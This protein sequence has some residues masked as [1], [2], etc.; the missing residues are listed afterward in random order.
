MRILLATDGS[1]DA[2]HARAVLEGLPLSAETTIRVLTVAPD[3][4][5]WF[6]PHRQSIEPAWGIRGVT[7]LGG[8]GT[9]VGKG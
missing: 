1:R 4:A 3:N 8:S 2:A 5:Y 7:R 9:R 6:G